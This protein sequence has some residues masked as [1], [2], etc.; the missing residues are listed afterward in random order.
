MIHNADHRMNNPDPLPHADPLQLVCVIF[1]LDGTLTR[2]NELIFASF[3]HVAQKY[4]GKTL[5][6]EEVIGFFGPP[7][8]RGMSALVGDE[9]AAPAMD[10]L[11]DYY[12]KNH[13]DLA[14]LHHGMEDILRFLKTHGVK[15]ALFTGKGRRTTD[16]TL[17]ELNI[18]RYFDLIV[19]G[20][21]VVN[22]KPHHEGI[23]RVLETLSL[24]PS[25]VL[26]VGD[27]LADLK[28]SRAAGIR[29]AAVVW[30]SYDRD[31]V[32]QSDADY[33]F[34]EVQ[35]LYVWLQQHVN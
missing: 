32:I 18:S 15:I 26:M 28:A 30:D 13:R 14:S 31:R 9:A 34:A 27:A 22:H 10:D 4:L 19:S 20:S 35:D 5:S 29:M 16:I 24:H 6:P 21:D 23:M 2:T 3:N 1:D 7:E 33:L 25:E 8:E 11:C 12:R 17:R